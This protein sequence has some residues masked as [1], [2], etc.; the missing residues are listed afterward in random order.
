MSTPKKTS[1]DVVPALIR[2]VTHRFDSAAELDRFNRGEEPTLFE[3]GRY[4]NPTVS[5]AEVGLA[6]LQGT[7]DAAL[8]ASGMAAA[9]TA[10][11][12]NL[13]AGEELVS[14]NAIYGGVFRFLRDVAPRWNLRTR[15]VDSRTLTDAATYGPQTRICYFE[16]PVNPTLRLVDIE[17]VAS[18]AKQAGAL[19][20]VDSTFA[21]PLQQR[22]NQLGVDLVIHSVT[23]SLNGH[24]D[25][26]GGV[27]CGTRE[28]VHKVK[29]L[30]RILGGNMDPT[31]A[32]E[33][34]R[35]M[36]TL[37][38]RHRRQQETAQLLAERLQK[39]PRVAAV[40]Y[41][42]LP[43]HPDHAL[44]KRQMQGF[45][46]MLTFTVKGSQPAAMQLFDTLKVIERAVSL[47]SVESLC[48][49][50]ALTSHTGLSDA[51]LSAAGVD[52]GMVRLSVGLE[53]AEELWQDLVQALGQAR[54]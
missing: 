12:A 17:A 22:P 10:I 28:N 9:T 13:S 19:S 8:F 25:V 44:A 29:M 30:R 53:P 26:L 47:G 23:K 3:Y 51:E 32:W 34:M 50:P 46:G 18:A 39:D 42:G 41:P 1:R 7:E 11:L 15:F 40:S 33:L 14:A 20:M 52:R 43:S 37:E 49:L 38:V 48:A 5:E 24:S 35:G 45:G 4:E 6:A 27:V 54:P 16:T 21:P 36:K 2:S 31:A